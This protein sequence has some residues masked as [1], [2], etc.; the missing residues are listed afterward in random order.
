M[1]IDVRS[2]PDDRRCCSFDTLMTSPDIRYARAR[3][4]N[5]QP[6][7]DGAV[8]TSSK[9]VHGAHGREC[10]VNGGID[11]C[12]LFASPRACLPHLRPHAD[13][14][15]DTLM[16]RRLPSA[17]T[18]PD[19]I[20]FATLM[21]RRRRSSKMSARRGGEAMVIVREIETGERCAIKSKKTRLNRRCAV[22]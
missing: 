19:V 11:A 3:R 13:V 16:R 8:R 17:H 21:P 7:R 6:V 4:G 10:R 20:I 22:R 14:A 12:R 2:P 5:Q 18:P 1:F 15:D 9:E